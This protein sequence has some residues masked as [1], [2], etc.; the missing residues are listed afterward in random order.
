MKI[1]NLYAPHM[2]EHHDPSRLETNQL[3]EK[4]GIAH[5]SGSRFYVLLPMGKRVFNSLQRIIRDSAL[6][7]GFQEISLPKIQPMKFLR[8]T[9]RLDS[10][11]TKVYRL[12]SEFGD[13]CLSRTNEETIN[14]LVRNNL[15]KRHLPLCLFQFGEVFSY[16]TPVGGLISNS[17]FDVFE[18]YSFHNGKGSITEKV[19]SFK[20]IVKDLCNQSN[21]TLHYVES[22]DGN[23]G[24][25]LLMTNR[26]QHRIFVCEGN[27]VTEYDKKRETC[28]VCEQKVRLQRGLGIA[29]F[30]VF[31]D[32]FAKK[33]DVKFRNNSNEEVYPHLATYGIGMSRLLY[34]IVEQNRDEEGIVWPEKLSPFDVYLIPQY[35]SNQ[36][37]LNRLDLLQ[38][39]MESVGMHILVDDRKNAQVNSKIKTSRF[40]GIPK[41][42]L[43][44]E[45]G[46]KVQN[47]GS[48]IQEESTLEQ[49]IR[50]NERD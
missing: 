38:E 32:F 24:N 27:H 20:E 49:I 41:T 3:I 9:G 23:Y 30:K 5:Y 48:S 34:A 18:A 29:M 35:P 6:R 10:Y 25:F 17:E 14:D 36:E 42:I 1:Q 37:L 46:L 21:L 12:S 44:T 50:E 15:F 45:N 43:I 33:L 40:I 16:N 47:R 11:V 19:D 22:N 28:I 8:E 31:D 26:G 2:L 13:F 7:E 39:K 4:A